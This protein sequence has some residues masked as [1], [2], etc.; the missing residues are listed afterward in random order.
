[1]ALD[2]RAELPESE[3]EAC[4]VLCIRRHEDIQV[5]CGSRDSMD[6]E[7]V[8][9]DDQEADPSPL[10]RDQEIPEVVVKD[11]ATQSGAPEQRSAPGVVP[12]S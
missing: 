11:R 3:H 12:R 7:S 4:C 10:Q 5:T 6:R 9:S 1:M 2:R 8:G